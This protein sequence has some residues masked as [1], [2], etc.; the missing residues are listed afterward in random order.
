M[1]EINGKDRLE[2]LYKLNKEKIENIK[3]LLDSIDKIELNIKYKI[4]L[5]Q[6]YITDLNKNYK[7][8]INL[9][10]TICKNLI[11]LN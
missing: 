11:K 6:K 10:H 3:I 8:S 1:S 2:K 7:Q 4:E 9:Y 5:H